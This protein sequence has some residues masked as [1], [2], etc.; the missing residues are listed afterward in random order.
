MIEEGGDHM[1]KVEMKEMKNMSGRADL[2]LELQRGINSKK[3]Q[4]E[5]KG[6]R[7]KKEKDM[8]KNM[9]RSDQ[10]IGK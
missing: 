10:D 1:K 9:K 5:E 2:S 6:I 7:V 4:M 3:T 8:R